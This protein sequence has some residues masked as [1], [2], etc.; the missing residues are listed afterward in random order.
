MSPLILSVQRSSSGSVPSEVGWTKISVPT[1]LVLGHPAQR[2]APQS[3]GLRATP[4]VFTS[5]YLF[6]AALLFA[7][8]IISRALTSFLLLWV[9]GY[10]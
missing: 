4:H 9:R 7:M 1:T 6:S 8:A 10:G 5:L 2:N 3:F